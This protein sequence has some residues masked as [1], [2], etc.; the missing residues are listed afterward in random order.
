MLEDRHLTDGLLPDQRLSFNGLK[1]QIIENLP[2][3]YR[4]SST[5]NVIKGFSV[6]F[7]M[8]DEFFAATAIAELG[9]PTSLAEDFNIVLEDNFMAS[10][11]DEGWFDA[12]A[13]LWEN[14]EDQI[15]ATKNGAKS[16][17]PYD[18]YCWR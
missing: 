9:P 8:H 6:R 14:V 10:Y 1:L 12:L 17:M 13:A 11:S 2:F 7:T 18:D 15:E 3:A 4:R 5:S 16:G